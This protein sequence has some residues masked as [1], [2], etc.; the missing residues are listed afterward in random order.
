MLAGDRKTEEV[1]D[2]GR[3]LKFLFTSE[4]LS[5]GENIVENS[6]ADLTVSFLDIGKNEFS[7][8]RLCV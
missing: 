2:K 4:D 6:L 5:Q 3:N 7:D 8:N 1:A